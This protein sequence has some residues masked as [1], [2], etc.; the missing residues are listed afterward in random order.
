MFGLKI[1]AYSK[2]VGSEGTKQETRVSEQSAGC[3]RARARSPTQGGLSL[4]ESNLERGHH[5]VFL[6]N[7]ETIPYSLSLSLSLSQGWSLTRGGIL[8]IRKRRNHNTRTIK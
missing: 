4:R 3:L 2:F 7:K 8:T 5:L 6:E 1:Y